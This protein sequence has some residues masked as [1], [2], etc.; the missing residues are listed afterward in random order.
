MIL[1][2]LFF[3]NKLDFTCII[4][5]YNGI[6]VL[7]NNQIKITTMNTQ[8]ITPINTNFNTVELIYKNNVADVAGYMAALDMFELQATQ[9][10]SN[11]SFFC[12]KSAEEVSLAYHKAKNAS[13]PYEIYQHA[14]AAEVWLKTA[15]ERAY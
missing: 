13:E 2:E 11:E 8:T 3:K 6:F 5:H 10:V 9:F 14:N 7:Q 1:S 15:Y 4:Y 12:R